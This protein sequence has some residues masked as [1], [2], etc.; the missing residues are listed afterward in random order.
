MH[1]VKKQ[2][3]K[4]KIDKPQG[5]VNHLCDYWDAC[6]MGFTETWRTDLD[7]DSTL[8]ISGFGVRLGQ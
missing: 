2:G 5:N 4:E 1:P 8:D 3:R 6:L 7:I